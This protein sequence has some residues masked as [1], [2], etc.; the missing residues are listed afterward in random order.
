MAGLF[1][2]L[3]APYADDTN[4]EVVVRGIVYVISEGEAAKNVVI[5]ESSGEGISVTMDKEG[6]KLEAMNKSMVEVTGFKENGV[7]RITTI[8]PM[9]SPTTIPP[10]DK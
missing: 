6:K 10:L 1:L 7:L 8:R 3:P 5:R 2:A 4:Q 9:P